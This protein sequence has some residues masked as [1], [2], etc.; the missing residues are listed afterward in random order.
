MPPFT[1]ECDTKAVTFKYVFV[2]YKIVKSSLADNGLIICSKFTEQTVTARS[3]YRWDSRI[4]GNTPFVIFQLTE[5]GEGVFVNKKRRWPVPADYAFVA[6]VPEASIYHYP[7]EAREPWSFVWT[8]FS[9]PLACSLFRTFQQEYGPVIYLSPHGAAA[10]TLR[11]VKVLAS[12]DQPDRRHL[13]LEVYAFLLEWW[14]ES[15]EPDKRSGQ[16]FDWA[17]RFCREHFREPLGIK[18]IAAESGLSR[19]HFSRLFTERMELTPAAFL[20]NLRLR[21]AEII[22][23][24]TRLPLSEVALRSGFS[25][26]RHLMGAFQRVHGQSPT[27]YRRRRG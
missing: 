10:A 27:Q 13:S 4:R 15:A 22:L 14:R 16:G 20:R 25:S 26:A 18:E 21:E 23:C 9:G 19:E 7:P 6:V 17:I 12:Q 1:F 2:I 11:R 5:S 24:Q 8:N 3:R